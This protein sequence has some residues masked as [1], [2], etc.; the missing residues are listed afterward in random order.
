MIRTL[1]LRGGLIFA[2]TCL[3]SPS[4]PLQ[5][6]STELGDGEGRI[7]AEGVCVIDALT[8]EPIFQK[9]ANERLYPASI[10]KILTALIVI[11]TGGLEAHMTIEEPETK[12]EPSKLY[13]KTG[14]TYER[15][16]MLFGL[17]LKSANDV[18]EALARDNAGSVAAFGERM[19]ARARELGATGSH[20]VNPNGLPNEAHYTTAHDMAVIARA[21]M[22]QP[23]FREI[24][25]TKTYEWVSATG[26]KKMLT[27]G[28]RLLGR[29]E[30]C[31]G[32]KT[33]WTNA[34]KHTLVSAALR[35]HREVI[36]VVLKASSRSTLWKQ[37][38]RLLEYGLG[39]LPE[40]PIRDQLDET[41]G[42]L[43]KGQGARTSRPLPTSIQIGAADRRSALLESAA[44]LSRGAKRFSQI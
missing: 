43:P 20:F 41:V 24:V 36:A 42:L 31:T 34:S 11:E 14:E 1:L 40:L 2:L 28:N 8:G 3:G 29:F 7:E 10:T 5:A 12:A 13:I 23:L 38:A 16:Q 9:N 22:M 30:G 17:L 19:T 4:A 18:A 35:D 37:S 32:L 25:S 39:H 6:A 33:G 15:K 26:E 27:N 44:T 21:A